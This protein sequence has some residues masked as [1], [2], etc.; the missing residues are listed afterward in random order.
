MSAAEDAQRRFSIGQHLQATVT[1]LP[2]AE[3]GTRSTSR[4][5]AAVM[6]YHV[7]VESCGHHD[8]SHVA[9]PEDQK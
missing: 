8:C 1:Q 2:S 4:H 5:L 3:T 7:K 9:L 6:G